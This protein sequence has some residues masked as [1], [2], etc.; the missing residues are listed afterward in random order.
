MARDLVAF[1][2]Q[3]GVFVRVQ[4]WHGQVGTG[5]GVASLALAVFGCTT[6]ATP[7]AVCVTNA[8]CPS[9]LCLAGACATVADALSPS[10]GSDALQPG[11]SADSADLADASACTSTLQCV[12]ADYS[13]PCATWQCVGGRCTAV[14]LAD[15]TTCTTA[16]VCPAAGV[17]KKGACSAVGDVC[18]DGNDCTLDVCKNN[19]CNHDPFLA[20]SSC[21][22]KTG[23]ACHTAVCNSLGGCS[24][25]LMPGHCWIDGQCNTAGAA[26]KG[27]PCA[28][29]LP[30]EAT[31]TWTVVD[32]GPCSDGDNCTSGDHCEDGG[33][34]SGKALECPG[35]TA[36]ASAQCDAKLGCV[37]LP[38]A[39][40]CTDSDPCTEG[41]ACVD[42]LCK[43]SGSLDCEDGNPCTKDSCTAGFGCLHTPQSGPCAFDAD[44]CTE[45]ACIAG[46]C[47]GKELFSVCQIAGKCVP[48]G[49]KPEN[50]PCL[51]CDPGFSVTSWKLLNGTACSDGSA[52][53][54]FDMCGGGKCAGSVVDCVDKNTCTSDSCDPAK[55]C[56]FAPMEGECTDKNACTINDLC[57]NGKCTGT[58]VVAAMCDDKNPCTTESCAQAF[59]CTS[60]PNTKPCDD[61]DP[62]TKFDACTA[63]KCIPGTI[64]CPCAGD[65]DCNDKNPCTLDACIS[66]GCNNQTVGTGACNDNNACT[67]SDGCNGVTCSGVAM[68]CD[69]G[70]SC[71]LDTCIAEKGCVAQPL[72]GQP[73]TDTNLCTS[74]DLCIDGNCTGTPKNC[75]DNNP[76]TLDLC[77]ATKGTC[78]HPA[79]GDGTACT[80]DDVACTLDICVGIQCTH[81]KVSADWCLITGTCLSGGAIH[82]VDPCLGCLPKISQQAWSPR[83]NLTCSDGNIC[84]AKDTCLAS[85]KCIGAALDCGDGNACTVDSC[86]PQNSKSPCFSVSSGGPCN[87]GSV[88]T[89]EDTCIQAVCAGVPVNCNDNKPCTVDGCAAVGGCTHSNA[90]NG[91]SCTADDLPCTDNSCAEGLCIAVVGSNWCVIDGQC[92][93]ANQS[94][95]GQVCLSCQP[96]NSQSNWSPLT[97]SPCDDGNPCSSG[98]A[99]QKG[100]CTPADA[101]TCDDS[102]PCTTDLCSTSTGCSHV[103]VN[104]GNCS[105]DSFC[106]V[107]DS[108]QAGK[109][110][111]KAVVCSASSADIAA[112]KVASCEAKSGCVV[113]STC[114]TSHAC[115]AGKCLSTVGGQKAQP[116]PV[117]FS[118]PA[119]TKPI[120]P[121]LRWHDAGNDALGPVPRLWVAAQSTNC[122]GSGAAG[123][124]VVI[125]YLPPGGQ[126]AK[127]QT[128]PLM[129]AKAGC[130]QNPQLMVHPGSFS[131][132]ALVWQETD[133]VCP[134]T[135]VR[136]GIV[137]PESKSFG[138]ATGCLPLATGRPAVAIKALSADF[139]SPNSLGGNLAAVDGAAAWL[140]SGTY[141]LEWS[142][143]EYLKGIGGL[144]S[145]VATLTGRPAMVATSNAVY[146]LTPLT[147]VPAAATGLDAMPTLQLDKVLLTGN[148]NSTKMAAQDIDAVA[149]NLSY[150]AVEATWDPES[151]RIG[152]ILSGTMQQSGQAIG[153]LAWLRLD[154]TAA[155]VAVPTLLQTFDAGKPSNAPL[156]AFRLAE[157]P[158]SSDFLVAWAFPGSVNLNL[159]RIKPL[160]DKKVLTV[161]TQT[162]ANDYQSASVGLPL[163]GSGGLSELVVAPKG[164]RFSLAYETAVGI[165]LVTLPV[166]GP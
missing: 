14:Q 78:D 47:K 126:P 1:W 89:A 163:A 130:A 124:S 152:A 101:G 106:T 162:V 12:L 7:T 145:S 6:L 13:V 97:G 73:C 90:A 104:G 131:Q 144:T 161:W 134:T 51:V 109:C 166:T 82:A 129:V 112:C 157:L 55:G 28:Q 138:P 10:T 150:F 20:G 11:D 108:C 72:Q 115:F 65:Q 148:A 137:A 61:G 118:N 17:C 41:D 123:S 154:I 142:K 64:I 68:V 50:Q 25:V 80:S 158:G 99:C 18:D 44:P 98:D 3:R 128:L 37:S 96:G 139:A 116:M 63:G 165:S 48:V 31:S 156:A 43:G 26:Q 30:E 147:F 84:T 110:V 119:G 35:S 45:D 153:F 95:A 46:E 58:A 146:L 121:T 114:P 164:D 2:R 141:P 117:A 76:C 122:G 60:A 24:A 42:L 8:D 143:P 127:M 75:D 9:G 15:G 56:V 34:C 19:G 67:A 54:Q 86:N 91:L 107:S 81:S 22:S 71:T 135:L 88:C 149:K 5:L 132:L 4:S 83:T 136:M 59:G 16:K 52:C 69:D 92:R 29:C 85:G 79:F 100:L 87:D 140:L 111:G 105:D 160:D 36:C 32:T 93:T 77:T 38:I 23:G 40:T 113:V 102:N 125:T 57:L 159:A 155:A 151:N 70:N 62:C 49:G 74:A 120:N 103:A 33:N 21:V 94:A 27:E 66:S 133:G 39:G 53:T